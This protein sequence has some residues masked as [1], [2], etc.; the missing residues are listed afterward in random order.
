[1]NQST[2]YVIGN[3]GNMK[4]PESGT[5]VF[6]GCTWKIGVSRPYS[7]FSIGDYYVNRNHLIC[8]VMYDQQSDKIIDGSNSNKPED[9]DYVIPVVKC[10]EVKDDPELCDGKDLRPK[11]IIITETVLRDVHYN[12][13]FT[14]LYDR[15]E[16]FIKL[17]GPSGC[18]SFVQLGDPHSKT[19][20]GSERFLPDD[21]VRVITLPVEV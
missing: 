14:P 4:Y 3:R 11:T 21:L 17:K 5:A 9:N 13:I 12:E 16:V 2:T 15:T 8:Q 19:F 1:M 7:T 6:R 20:N 10:G 18:C